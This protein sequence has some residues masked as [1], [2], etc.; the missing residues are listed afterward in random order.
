MEFQ[1]PKLTLFTGNRETPVKTAGRYY[2][3]SITEVDQANVLPAGYEWHEAEAIEG[4]PQ[5]QVQL[6]YVINP[7]V[8]GVKQ[9]TKLEHLVDFGEQLPLSELGPT[10]ITV[11]VMEATDA[12]VSTRALADWQMMKSNGAVSG[13]GGNQ[14]ASQ[15]MTTTTGT[16]TATSSTSNAQKDSP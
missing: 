10:E 14:T 2:L 15:L 9:P 12:Q 8:E 16:G 13:S 1:T 7:A 6:F 11:E 5:V 4:R 3:Y